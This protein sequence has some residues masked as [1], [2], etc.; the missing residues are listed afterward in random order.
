[1]IYL[2]VFNE[3][4]IQKLVFTLRPNTLMVLASHKLGL[5][6]ILIPFNGYDDKTIA[7]VLGQKTLSMALHHSW[8]TNYTKSL[9]TL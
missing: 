8:Q 6:T 7:G 5:Q 1:M 3:I 2:F 9:P 4:F